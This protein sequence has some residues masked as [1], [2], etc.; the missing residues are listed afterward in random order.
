MPQCRLWSQ[1]TTSPYPVLGQAAQ[2]ASQT[3]VVQHTARLS[4][5]E[6]GLLNIIRAINKKSLWPI[7]LVLLGAEEGAR[8]E[9]EIR[10]PPT[11]GVSGS[12]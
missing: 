1:A 12:W 6:P 3:H 11:C 10:S 4:G 7:F 9:V 8:T 5:I 2:T